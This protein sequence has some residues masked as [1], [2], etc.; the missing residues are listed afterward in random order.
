MRIVLD[1]SALATILFHEADA[2][3]Y[4]MAMR[5]SAGMVLS[6]MTL[7]ETRTVLMGRNPAAVQ[8]L[9]ELMRVLG[10]S[11]APFD[12]QQAET[13]FAAYTRFGKGRDNRAS[14]NLGDCA[15]Y[16]LARTLNAPL[17]FKGRDFV[18]TDIIAAL[19]LLVPEAGASQS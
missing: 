2:D 11:A 14:L 5:R 17:L 18:H 10:I 9:D 6:A 15:A 7:F 4:L 3:H 1:T 16:A 8:E 12:E 13:A 19:P